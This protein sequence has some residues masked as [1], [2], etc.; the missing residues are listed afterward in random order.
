MVVFKQFF[1]KI[2][3]NNLN[4]WTQNFSY[5]HFVWKRAF[6]LEIACLQKR[7]LRHKLLFEYRQLTLC[8]QYFNMRI[9]DFP[10]CYLKRGWL[11]QRIY[12]KTLT[13]DIL[14]F[15]ESYGVRPFFTFALYKKLPYFLNSGSGGLFSFSFLVFVSYSFIFLHGFFLCWNPSSASLTNVSKA[16]QMK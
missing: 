14:I 11:N 2:T 3:Q 15:S 5:E 13:F 1:I 16:F 8:R 4:Y 10:W 9:K 6:S 12:I 7:L